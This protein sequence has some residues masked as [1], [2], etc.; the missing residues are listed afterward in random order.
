[1]SSAHQRLAGAVVLVFCL[2]LASANDGEG[3]DVRCVGFCALQRLDFRFQLPALFAA[4]SPRRA[5]KR[6]A[7][8]NGGCPNT[9]LNGMLLTQT[10]VLVSGGKPC[11]LNVECGI[12][13]ANLQTEREYTASLS[14]SCENGRCVCATGSYG[15]DSCWAQVVGGTTLREF[16]SRELRCIVLSRRLV[17]RVLTP[18]LR[19][20]ACQRRMMS[21]STFA[22]STRVVVSVPPI[23][24]A[25]TGC[26]SKE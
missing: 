1:M 23:P 14:G 12:P 13:S 3:R 7:G 24:S 15:C 4:S 2:S 5:A 6:A 11:Q 10:Y 26:A 22:L 9:C 16:L 8:I 20:G 17:E 21:S 18:S 25:T 19:L